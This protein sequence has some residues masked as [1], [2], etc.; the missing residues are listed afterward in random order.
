M[1]KNLIELRK[2]KKLS[3]NKISQQLGISTSHYYKIESGIRNPNFI[4]AGK[5]A[6]LFNCTVDEIFFK[7]VLDELSKFNAS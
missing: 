6:K 1:R 7:E 2:T 4:L 3:V 5:I